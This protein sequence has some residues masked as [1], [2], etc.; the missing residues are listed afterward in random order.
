MPPGRDLASMASTQ[1]GCLA[2]C[3]SSSG[4]TWSAAET[5]Y[6]DR[7]TQAAAQHHGV[8]ER[9]VPERISVEAAPLMQPGPGLISRS[10]FRL[11]TVAQRSAQYLGF[12]RSALDCLLA[13]LRLDTP[14]Q[15]G[16][17]CR[18]PIRCRVVPVAGPVQA[19]PYL[20]LVFELPILFWTGLVT[21][22]TH[23]ISRL[24]PT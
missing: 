17:F 13:C 14:A 10:Q 6:H 20:A 24:H 2:R 5:R 16:C 9:K 21:P 7:C 11:R 4:G 3:D 18:G 22:S 19:L 1:A 12:A 23:P 8:P 15:L